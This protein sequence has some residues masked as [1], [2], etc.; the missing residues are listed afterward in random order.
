M[1]KFSIEF[2]NGNI[3]EIELRRIAEYRAAIVFSG[4]INIGSFEYQKEL[5]VILKDPVFARDYLE[6][7]ML[8]RDIFPLGSFIKP[9]FHYHDAWVKKEV[10]IK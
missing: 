9:L 3:F 7:D 5:D 8:W 6:N 1:K 4:M 2:A 10:K